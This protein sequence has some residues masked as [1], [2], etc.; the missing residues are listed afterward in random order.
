M[1]LIFYIIPRISELI[2]RKLFTS[3]ELER[4]NVQGRSP[5]ASL[6]ELGWH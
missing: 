5:S 4:T 3:P 2:N 1:Q 6:L